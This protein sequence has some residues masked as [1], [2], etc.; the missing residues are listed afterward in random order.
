MVELE[1]AYEAGEDRKNFTELSMG[2]GICFV[3]W[4]NAKNR[5]TTTPPPPW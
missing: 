5:S 4:L 2:C 1:N 3:F